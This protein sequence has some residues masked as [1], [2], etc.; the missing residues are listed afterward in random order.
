MTKLLLSTGNI[1]GGPAAMGYSTE[2]RS[3]TELTN[4]LRMNFENAIIDS[5]PSTNGNGTENGARVPRI[6]YHKWTSPKDNGKTICVPATNYNN[7]PLQEER[8]QYDITAKLFYLPGTSS[9]KREE[10]TRE[11]L[12]Q[13]LEELKMPS[14]DL[15]IVSFPG[16]YF[17]EES[18][19]CPV[20][21]SSRGPAEAE[22]ETQ[23]SQIET[24]KVLEKLHD[25]GLVLKL[26]LSEFGT[27]RLQPFLEHTRIRPAVN[28]IN[29]RDCC[30]VPKPLLSLAKTHDIELLVHNDCSNIL[31]RGTLRELLGRGE[32]GAGILA[33]G[34]GVGEKRKERDGEE[35]SGGIRGEVEPQWV[36]KYTAVVQNR[37]VVENKGYFA[38]AEVRS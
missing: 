17:D 7:A 27:E 21:I 37:G 13:V 20:K 23:E 38:L 18:E 16:I 22:P 33:A 26:G 10:Q 8:E 5:T 15:L 35:S 12:K 24:W 11:A 6:D 9:E 36:I 25:E 29:L 19:D 4:C 31:P 28:Q 2:Q 30:S 34:S 3:N 1:M 14:I 32:N